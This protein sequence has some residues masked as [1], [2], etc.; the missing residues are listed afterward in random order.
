[1]MTMADGIP[2][3]KENLGQDRFECTLPALEF[4]NGTYDAAASTGL[5]G[6]VGAVYR[7]GNAIQ[8]YDVL[9]KIIE[10]QNTIISNIDD[11]FV[12]NP[13]YL[14]TEL[15]FSGTGTPGATFQFTIVNAGT[16]IPSTQIFR[17]N[18]ITW[19]CDG[20]ETMRESVIY[21]DPAA[22]G[23]ENPSDVEIINLGMQ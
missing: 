16:T 14:Q 22:Y 7:F 10:L 9:M 11:D 18:G 6:Q 17:V 12:D 4:R 19:D 23:T 5:I 2:D 21:Y 8:G 20:T 1:M 3:A 15:T 13:T